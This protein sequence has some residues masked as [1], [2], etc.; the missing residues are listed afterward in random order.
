MLTAKT[1]KLGQGVVMGML[2]LVLLLM[3]WLQDARKQITN[4][5][6]YEWRREIEREEGG[7]W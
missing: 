6:L 2:L 7:G 3:Q 5:L 1:L 4:G